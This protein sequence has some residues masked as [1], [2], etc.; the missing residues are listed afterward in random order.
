VLKTC[1][2]VLFCAGE[3]A[4]NERYNEH[5]CGKIEQVLACADVVASTNSKGESKVIILIIELLW[6]IRQ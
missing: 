6:N 2:K 4:E 1:T 3:K 5:S